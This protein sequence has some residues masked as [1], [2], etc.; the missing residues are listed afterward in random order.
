MIGTWYSE[1]P[2]SS[3]AIAFFGGAKTASC[4]AAMPTSEEV[5]FNELEQMQ[6]YVRP[7]L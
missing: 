7:I 5:A 4:E 1:T 6:G 3:H 2:T